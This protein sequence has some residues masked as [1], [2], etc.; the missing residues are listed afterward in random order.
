MSRDSGPFCPGLCCL[1]QMII[2]SNY[3]CIKNNTSCFG[4]HFGY[5]SN[6]EDRWHAPIVKSSIFNKWHRSCLKACL[7]LMLQSNSYTPRSAHFY[8][9]PE[10]LIFE[11]T[12]WRNRSNKRSILLLGNSS[13][14]RSDY[15]LRCQLPASGSAK[16]EVGWWVGGHGIAKMIHHLQWHKILQDIHA[17][18]L[19]RQ[20]RH[21]LHVECLRTS[22]TDVGGESCLNGSH[23]KHRGFQHLGIHL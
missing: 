8:L 4:I 2:S 21:D 10:F 23:G 19:L 14:K 18:T 16:S 7:K 15:L 17:H 9:W 12:S 5:L 20:P 3:P 1:G 6:Y 13:S 11:D 22:R